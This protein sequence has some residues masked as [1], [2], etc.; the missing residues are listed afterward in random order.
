MVFSKVVVA[1]DGSADAERGL[2]WGIEHVQVHGGTLEVLTSA[3]EADTVYPLDQSGA[4]T[5]ERIAG[6]QEQAAGRLR[7]AGVEGW[8]TDTTSNRIVPELIERSRDASLVVVG[9]QGHGVL[10]GKVLGSVSQHV[11]RHAQSPVVVVRGAYR[12]HS[13]RVVVGVDGSEANRKALAF[14]FAHAAATGGSI[15]A[16]HG[17]SMQSS[18]PF[19][20]A[21]SRKVAAQLAESERLLEESLT[22]LRQE[23]PEVPVEQVALP[24]PPVRALADAS[25]NASLVVVGTRGLGG[26]SGLLLGSVSAGVLQRAQCP[27]AV[28][29]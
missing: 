12:A 6:W 15:M 10:G 28:V 2:E 5:D 16:V 7:E 21:I 17:R 29:R 9:A 8:R 19:D 23:H 22:E 1:Y 11:T 26:F 14:A 18:G 4:T 3:G 27:V 24:L 13:P 25:A 20:A